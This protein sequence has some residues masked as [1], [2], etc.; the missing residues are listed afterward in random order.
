MNIDIEAA[1][2]DG[3]GLLWVRRA[4]RLHSSIARAVARGEL[5]RVMRGCYARAGTVTQRVRCVALQIADPD[6][7]FVGETA[8]WLLDPSGRREPGRVEVA[9][10][11]LR[12]ATP[13]L[14]TVE[15]RIDPDHIGQVDG[16]NVTGPTL[17]ALDLARTRGGAPLDDA[18]RAGIPLSRLWRTLLATAGRRG[19]ARLRRLLHDSRDEPWSPA[20]R[21]AH[22]LLRRA[23]ITGWTANAAV[24]LPGRIVHPDIAFAGI[25]LAIELD[26]FEFHGGR[27]QFEADR[28]RDVDLAL[29]GWVVYRFSASDVFARP[30]EFIERV[31]A[32]VELRSLALAA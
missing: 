14:R 31:S 29:A 23:G 22:R 4:R 16:L 32:L 28:T 7:V 17:T 2:A 25:L 3:G 27:A 12:L 6:A 10:R 15:R 20:E 8:A 26:G 19:N 11:R 9:T 5:E 21:E 18:L 24:A 13:H 30:R 1:L